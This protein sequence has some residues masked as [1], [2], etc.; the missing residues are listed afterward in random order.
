MSFE[1]NARCFSCLPSRCL[2][3]RYL[4]IL[5]QRRLFLIFFSLLFFPL[6]SISCRQILCIFSIAIFIFNAAFPSSILLLLLRFSFL[7]LF[8]FVYLF[9]INFFLFL[10][11]IFFFDLCSSTLSIFPRCFLLIRLQVSFS[12][13]CS[14]LFGKYW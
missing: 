10:F 11:T 4:S 14:S 1:L 8:Y 2:A 9:S 7:S 6:F 3:E 13:F 12:I 5:F